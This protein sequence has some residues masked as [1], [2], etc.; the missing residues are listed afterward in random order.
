[1]TFYTIF[2]FSLQLYSFLSVFHG[3]RRDDGSALEIFLF[4]HL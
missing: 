2:S 1:M 4:L 3:D